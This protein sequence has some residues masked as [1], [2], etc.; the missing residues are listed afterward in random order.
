MVTLIMMMVISLIVVG[1]TQVVIR[2]RR[3]SLDKQLSSQA[4]YAAESGVN[5]AIDD[6]NA[7]DIGSIATK[8]SCVNNGGHYGLPTLNGTDV[9]V[10]CIMV[11]TNPTNILG[12]ATQTGSFVSYVKPVDASGNAQ[13]L[14]SI[15]FTWGPADGQTPRENG[16]TGSLGAFLT[17]IP[18]DCAFGLLRVELLPF[19]GNVK[20]GSSTTVL[21]VQ[22]LS[23]GDGS[24]SLGSLGGGHVVD[25]ACSHTTK[26]CKAT[27][28]GAGIASSSDYYIRLSSLY[29]DIPS[30]EISGVLNPSGTARFK[31]SQAVIDVTGRAQDVLRR[32]QVRYPLNRGD[33]TPPWAVAGQVCKRLSVVPSPYSVTSDAM[34]N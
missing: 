31:D 10:T 20:S 1:F 9:A 21:Y 5:S 4:L 27:I 34:C 32:V 25:A 33:E 3:D 24:H 23:S 8:E 6:I 26:Q 22:P 7:Q 17:A 30:F 19:G 13:S 16:C 18:T 29:R 14:S 28:T 12:S 15:T 11:K 2:S